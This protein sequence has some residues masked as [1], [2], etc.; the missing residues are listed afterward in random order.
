MDKTSPPTEREFLLCALQGNASAVGFCELLAAISQTWDD[1]VDR[2]VEVT[3]AQVNEAFFR[4]VIELP[5]NR[6]Y[7]DHFASLHPLLQSSV[8]D[9]LTANEFERGD[10]HEKTLAFVLR[11]SLT[12]VVTQCAAIIGGHQ[13]AI[14]MS[15]KIRRYFQDE[16][17]QKYLGEQP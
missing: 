13:W 11:D 17:L 10:A 12:A 3:A 7:Q 6:F 4:A 2:D 8:Y 16:T 5:A 15:P 14:A 9:W 1:L